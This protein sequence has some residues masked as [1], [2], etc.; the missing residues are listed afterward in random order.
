ALPALS[1]ASELPQDKE[2]DHA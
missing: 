2:D 1:P